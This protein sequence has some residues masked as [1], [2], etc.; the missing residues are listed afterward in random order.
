MR[1]KILFLNNISPLKG[2]WGKE[3]WI[4]ACSAVWAL[5]VYGSI[6]IRRTLHVKYNNLYDYIFYLPLE[7]LGKRQPLNYAQCFIQLHDGPEK[8]TK[9]WYVKCSS[10]GRVSV[11]APLCALTFLAWR[12][13]SFVLGYVS[14]NLCLLI[15]TRVVNTSAINSCLNN[16]HVLF[17]C[18]CCDMQGKDSSLLHD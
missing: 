1:A 15:L 6:L 10:L 11:T 17:Y 16:Q 14:F 9:M 13:R 2:W 4:Q 12:T 7:N 18:T 3:S 5:A 8:N